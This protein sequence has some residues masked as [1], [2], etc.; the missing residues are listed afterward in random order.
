MSSNTIHVTLECFGALSEQMNGN[1]LSLTLPAPCTARQLLEETAHQWPDASGLLSQT[2][3]AR[4]DSLLADDEEIIDGDTIALV[5]PVSGGQPCPEPAPHLQ[6]EPLNLDHLMQETEDE[7]SGALVV[8]GGTVRL[9]N[10]GQRVQA[11]DYSAYG[12]LA[13]RTLADIERETLAAHDIHACR[14]QHRTGKLGLGEVS[15]Y[16]VVRAKHRQPAFE[17]ASHAL[18]QLKTRVAIWKNEYYQDGSSAYLEGTAVPRP[19][20]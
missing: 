11:M 14:L 3:C 17:A 6:A 12:P 5:P 13:A 15:V 10:A 19:E 9:D 7:R 1:S 18:E 16:V 20:R 4:G 2:A 8:F